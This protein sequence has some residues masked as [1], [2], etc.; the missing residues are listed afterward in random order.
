[1]YADAPMWMMSRLVHCDMGITTEQ[2]FYSTKDAAQK[3]MQVDFEEIQAAW[4][5]AEGFPFPTQTSQED[6]DNYTNHKD[7][8][9]VVCFEDGC[10]FYWKVSPCILE[11]DNTTEEA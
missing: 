1:L 9:I 3:A 8:S 4:E 11:P 5:E 6:R 2:K 10:S 7:T